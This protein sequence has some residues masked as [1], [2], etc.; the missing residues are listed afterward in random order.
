[1]FRGRATVA[2]PLL[3]WIISDSKYSL[4]VKHKE[5]LQPDLWDPLT[6][7]SGDEWA[8]RVWRY[9]PATHGG[10]TQNILLPFLCK[11]ATE[12]RCNLFCLSLLLNK[13]VRF[14]LTSR[15]KSQAC[16]NF[17]V[18]HDS[19]LH[20]HNTKA[21]RHWQKF[22]KLARTPPPQ[23]KRHH[24]GC[25]FWKNLSQRAKMGHRLVAPDLHR[26]QQK[27][28]WCLSLD[29]VPEE[30]YVYSIPAGL[31]SFS[32]SLCGSNE[33]HLAHY[34]AGKHIKSK[35]AKNTKKSAEWETVHP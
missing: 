30:D 20:H 26:R 10:K 1:M 32:E 25:E 11:C 3:N 29:G 18:L 33:Y 7:Q 24:V 5:P 9:Q 2:P 16:V 6:K 19:V 12:T 21:L 13:H 31:K 22:T 27:F 17:F 23:I 14:P 35:K 4:W 28:P 15:L 8:P 34:T